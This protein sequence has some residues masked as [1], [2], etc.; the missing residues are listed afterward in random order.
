MKKLAWSLGALALFLLVGGGAGYLIL[1][2]QS[3]PA[4]KAST[5]AAAK[6]G[7]TI[8]SAERHTLGNPDAPLTVIEYAALTCPHCAEFNEQVFPTLKSKYIDTGKV[9][10]VLRVLPISPADF[11]AEGLAACQPK[12]RYFSAV[13]TL[14]RRQKD[15]GPMQ[16]NEHVGDMNA[17]PKTDAGLI[18]LGVE[19]GLDAEKARS[20]MYDYMLHQT[21]EQ[22]ARESAGRY[23]I[24]GVPHMIVNGTEM[25][26]PHT[27]DELARI[28]DPLLEGK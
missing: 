12:E 27:T 19:M 5:T 13:D 14:F 28:L 20:C 3:R 15:W 2:H 26:A 6:A 1:Q 24:T 21:V 25:S 7:E 4:A 18:R 23:T 8:T 9:H 17:Q 11:K 16:M 22:I 10:Y